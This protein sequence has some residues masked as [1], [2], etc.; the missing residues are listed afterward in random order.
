MAC[1]LVRAIV[2]KWYK[3]LSYAGPN[4]IK[5]LFKHTNGVKLT[6]LTTK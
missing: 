6:E 5:Q 2:L 3:I 1:K 4:A